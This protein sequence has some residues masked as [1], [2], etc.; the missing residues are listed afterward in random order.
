MKMKK[1]DIFVAVYVLTAF[2][3]FIVT[4]PNWLLDI[5][6]AVNISI[7]FVILFGSMFVKEVLDLSFFP[8]T[9]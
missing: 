9:K 5:F 6:L 1:A 4:L 7:A 8:T 3:M 2:I